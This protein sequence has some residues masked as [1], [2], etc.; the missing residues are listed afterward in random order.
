[1]SSI[2]QKPEIAHVSTQVKMRR[3]TDNAAAAAAT[4]RIPLRN[5]PDSI[6]DEPNLRRIFLKTKQNKYIQTGSF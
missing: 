4:L 3:A 6:P 5:A 2:K 1:M